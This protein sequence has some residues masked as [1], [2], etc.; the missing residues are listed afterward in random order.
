MG[1]AA[2]DKERA[3]A[4]DFLR[5]ASLH[6]NVVI[7]RIDKDNAEVAYNSPCSCLTFDEDGKAGC[8]I[9]EDRPEICKNFPE[10]P[11]VN[12]PGFRFVEDIEMD[13][14]SKEEGGLR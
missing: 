11:T 14:V 8:S 2:T 10:N 6:E 3:S 9:Y 12:C 13:D 1:H 7:K 5:W 4:E